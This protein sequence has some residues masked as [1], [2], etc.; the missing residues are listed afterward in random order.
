MRYHFYSNS[1]S[2]GTRMVHDLHKRLIINILPSTD[3][4]SSTVSTSELVILDVI[5]KNRNFPLV[6]ELLHLDISDS[7]WNPHQQQNNQRA[8]AGTASVIDST[9]GCVYVDSSIRGVPR[10]TRVRG[11]LSDFSRAGDR[12]SWVKSFPWTQHYFKTN[13][14]CVLDW[15]LF[16]DGDGE[17]QRCSSKTFRLTAAVLDICSPFP[18][19][20]YLSLICSLS[21]TL[22]FFTPPFPSP[23]DWEYSQSY[24]V[25]S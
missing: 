20:L 12:T 5:W 14:I 9:N 24:G 10:R 21:R 2:T 11:R 7:T 22:P 25:W 16:S 18:F 1:S 6:M 13:R 3:A 15:S 19:S 8:L 4:F 23:V 17:R